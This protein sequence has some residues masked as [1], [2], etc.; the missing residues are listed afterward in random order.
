MRLRCH[1]NRISTLLSV[2]K[3]G[4]GTLVHNAVTSFALVTGLLG[5]ACWILGF[6]APYLPIPD[7]LRLPL[8]APAGIAIDSTG[9]VYI[10]SQFYGRIQRY[11]PGG[12]YQ[13]GFFVENGGGKF[14]LWVDLQD[15]IH[16]LAYRTN[17]HFVYSPS[18]QL[19]GWSAEQCSIKRN[20][21]SSTVESEGAVFEIRNSST[22]PYIVRQRGVEATVLIRDDF[23]LWS[24]AGPFPAIALV[25]GSIL[26]LMGCRSALGVVEGFRLLRSHAKSKCN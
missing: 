1:P 24:L 13:N 2:G 23:W 3:R 18:G 5:A 26:V 21:E 9:H 19:I 10:G 22:W 16:V 20:G 7:S 8:G 4:N 12:N 14:D 17:K 25:I 6:C 15:N 11:D